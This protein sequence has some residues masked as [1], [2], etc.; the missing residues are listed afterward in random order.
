MRFRALNSKDFQIYTAGNFFAMNGIWINRVIIGWLGWEL[1]GLASLVGLLSFFIF[2]PTVIASPFFGVIIDRVNLKKF[3]IITQ[4]IIAITVFALLLLYYFNSLTIFNLC[5]IALVI[6]ITTSADRSTRMTLVPRIVEKDNIANAIA[7][8]GINFNSA[9]L[10]GPALGGILIDS[11][12]F[13][14]T[15][16]INFTFFLCMPFA[17][18]LIKIRDREGKTQKKKNIFYEFLDGARFAYNQPI[19]L[20]ACILT[21]LFSLCARG[22]IEILPAIAG[23]IYNQGAQGLGQMLAGAG[24]GALVAALYIAS[25]RSNDPEKGIPL[26]VYVSSVFGFLALIGLG[27]SNN[28]YLAIVAVFIIG[29]CMTINGIDLQAVVQLE[30]D[31]VYRGRVMSLWVVLVIGVAAFSAVLMGL[32]ADL[33]GIG[34]T[35]MF[36]S[37]LGLTLFTMMLIFNGKKN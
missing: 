27:Y 7:V 11:I 36:F 23:G 2:A 9:R 24:A 13:N 26:R 37:I 14:L 10:I 15:I 35:L 17:L 33:V 25:Q 6:G 31:D 30:L 34:S 28:W 19:I 22:A 3:A 20:K 5:I 32:F 1:T 8:H 21:A 4:T 29:F 12:G 16:F 18:T